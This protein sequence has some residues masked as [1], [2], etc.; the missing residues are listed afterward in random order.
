MAEKRKPPNAGKGRVKGVPNK[1]T[2][3]ARKTFQMLL[4]W[5]APQMQEWLAKVAKKNPDRALAH[6]ENLAD[7]CIPRLG[8]IEHTGEITHRDVSDKP[9]SDA[10]WEAAYGDRMAPPAGPAES[11]H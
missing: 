7:F 5:A 9:L 11:T 2:T 8:R 6:V 1:A 10:E 4:E 3:D